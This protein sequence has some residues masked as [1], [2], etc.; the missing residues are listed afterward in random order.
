MFLKRKA[1]RLARSFL[2][3]GFVD[4]FAFVVPHLHS[5]A[6]RGGDGASDLACLVEIRAFSFTPSAVFVFAVA[7]DN[8]EFPRRRLKDGVRVRFGRFRTGLFLKTTGGGATGV[9][10]K[11]SMFVGWNFKAVLSSKLILWILSV[12]TGF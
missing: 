2:I 7:T 1:P 12:K 3:S 9:H 4:D 11:P 8:S 5:S 6:G 10:E